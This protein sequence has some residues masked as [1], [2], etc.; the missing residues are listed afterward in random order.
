MAT[1]CTLVLRQNRRL[2]LP[3][4]NGSP[5]TFEILTRWGRRGWSGWKMT[6]N[7]VASPVVCRHSGN[8]RVLSLS[9]Q[10]WLSD[11]LLA[12]VTSLLLLLLLLLLL[13]LV[14]FL[15]LLFLLLLL[16]LLVLLMIPL[17]FML[18]LLLL[19]LLFLLLLPQVVGGNPLL[20]RIDLSWC[21]G[22]TEAS[23]QRISVSFPR[24]THLKVQ[25]THLKLQTGTDNIR[26]GTDSISQGTDTTL[27]PW[28][29]PAPESA[30]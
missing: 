23:L 19:L 21:P 2:S 29:T 11:E 26:Q 22:L 7:N 1:Q 15:L 4:G 9:N 5:Q 14:L 27:Q 18:L 16:L 12:P 6:E 8:L 28:V 13:I 20:E 25:T 30:P 10:E 17:L 24:L 3:P